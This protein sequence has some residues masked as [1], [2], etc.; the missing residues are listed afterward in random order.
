MK[1]GRLKLH[2]VWIAD[3]DEAIR[4]VLE[5]S[6]SSSGFETKTFSSGEELIKELENTKPDLVITDVQM[7]GMLGYDILKHINNNF[8]DLPVIVMTAFADMQAAI[9]SF[10]GGAFE[11]IPKPFDLEAAIEIINRALETK[12]KTKG[13]KKN[14]KLDIIGESPAMQEVFRSIGKLSNTI[15]TV[16]IQGE[17]GTGKELIANSLHKNSPRH[18]MPFIA[19]NMADIPKELV[20]SE[21]FGHEKGSFTGAVGQRIGRFEQANGGTLFLDEIGDM[22]LDSQTRLLRVLSNKEFY[23]VGGDKP[24]KVDVRIIAATHQNLNNLVSQKI[25]REDLFYRLN[26]IR[27]NVPPL[28]ERKEDIEDLSKYFLK[29]FAS[30]LDEDLRVLDDETKEIMNKYDWPGN[31]R[32]LENVCYW[33]TLMSPSQNVKVKDLPN[34]VKELEIADMP[35]TSWE[36]GLQNW[37]KNVSMN[38]DSGLSEIAITKIEKMLIKTALERSNGKKNDAAQI[39]GWGRN[40][41]SKKMKEHGI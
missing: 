3:D 10:G 31:V 26:V 38:I 17:S 32:Q 14:T 9:E 35:S 7:P 28:K 24:V 13:L 41:L 18:D 11:Y 15:A 21:L 23:R 1:K 4:V 37:L 27:I 29:N 30:S 20:E 16:L 34:E 36:D 2:K 6:L 25:F 40:T 39:L 19:L 5:E 8:D 12:P 33:L 22:P